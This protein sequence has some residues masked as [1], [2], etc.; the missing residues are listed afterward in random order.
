MIFPSLPG[1]F[2]LSTPPLTCS[3]SF[4]FSSFLF[5]SFVQVFISLSSCAVRAFPCYTALVSSL[6]Y[7]YT[8]MKEGTAVLFFS[9][10]CGMEPI[11]RAIFLMP[12]TDPGKMGQAMKFAKTQKVFA[13]PRRNGKTRISLRDH[14]KAVYA[15]NQSARLLNILQEGKT[16]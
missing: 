11:R 5:I 10:S 15:F 13:D 6:S 2:S 12:R 14:S 8:R 1:A 3:S 4:R 7:V 16:P 9:A